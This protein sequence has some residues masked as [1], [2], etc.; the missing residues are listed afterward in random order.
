MKVGAAE[1][2]RSTV[3]LGR[4]SRLTLPDPIADRLRLRPA[5]GLPEQIHLSV[6]DRCFLPCT[7]CDIFRNKT[8]DLPTSTWMRVIDELSDWLGG[9]AMN[10]VGGEPLLRKDLEALMGH[11]VKRGFS[12]TFNSNGWLIDDRRAKAIADAG[13]EIAYLALDG[14]TAET[15]DATRG[16]EGSFARTIEAIERFESLPNPR[17]VVACI[18][19]AGNAH[20]VPGLLERL[21][22]RGHQLV[23]QPLYQAFGENAHQPGWH[24]AS[25][26]WPHRA[27]ELTAID[28]ALDVLIEA[29]LADGPV[30]NAV[31][32]LEAMRTYFRAPTTYNGLTCKA[33]HS[34]L[35]FDPAGNIRLCYFLEPIGKVMEER[36]FSNIWDR[37]ISQRRRWEVSRCTR[38]CNLLNCNFDRQDL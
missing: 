26:I 11:A 25:S 18:L 27:E 2:L 15:V 13:V 10:F 28:R 34:D 8:Q 32:Q 36:S 20:E 4:P 38:Q 14:A 7:H 31:E 16:R 1:R 6:T 33:G 19:H 37:Y 5:P 24:R 22:D 35:A 12:V 17:V 29:R 9:G 23:V 30:C 3:A 21:R